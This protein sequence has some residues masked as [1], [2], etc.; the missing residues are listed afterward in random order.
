M[1][2]GWIFT[3]GLNGATEFWTGGIDREGELETSAHRCD[4]YV[5]ASQSAALQCSD[6]HPGLKDSDSWKVVMR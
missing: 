3:R 2:H 1:N 5:F 4:A 6:T